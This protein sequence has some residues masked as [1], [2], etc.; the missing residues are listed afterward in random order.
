MALGNIEADFLSRDQIAMLLAFVEQR[1]GGL[2]I[3]GARSFGERGVIG[4]EL[5][6]ILAVE[7]RGAGAVNAAAAASSRQ[8]T[9]IELTSS[10]QQHPVMQLAP[11]PDAVA[12]PWN[13]LPSLAAA[14]AVGRTR[15]GAE[16][17]ALV[18]G[19]AGEPQPLV[20][21]Q[22]A[23][24]GRTLL[25]TGEGAW[26]WRMGLASGNVAY[27]T[28]WR[29]ALRWVAVQA[30]APVSVE[31]EPPPL[32]TAVPIAVRVVTPAFEPVSDAGVQVRVEEPGGAARTLTASLDSSEPGLYRASLLTLAPGVH[33]IDV[34]A[35]RGGQ[36]LGRSSVQV[37][38]GGTDPEFVDPR[39]NDAVLRRLGEATG[40]ALLEAS[41]LAGL[42]D[43]I[44]R[45]A[46]SPTARLVERDV[47]H[48]GWSFVIICALLGLEWALRRRWGL[49]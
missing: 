27:E 44:R 47:W 4:T 24:R 38:A 21:V 20:A 1:G 14:A 45:A 9:R 16:V 46:A 30:P 26:R 19:P 11:G 8:G 6:R 41:A 10:G 18:S 12:S 5:G 32:G 39:R 37:L 2:A 28:F 17:L 49:R 48:N 35:S 31:V 36:S 15:P 29:Q 13:A 23:G 34:D 40:G 7:A 43:R 33:R 25:F 3:I 22:R 42:P